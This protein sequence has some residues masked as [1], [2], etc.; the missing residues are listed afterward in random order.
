MLYLGIVF[1]APTRTL[2]LITVYSLT[3]V[4]CGKPQIQHGRVTG[5]TQ[6][7]NKDQYLTFECNDGYK[8]A[9]ERPSKCSKVGIRAEWSPTP[10]CEGKYPKRSHSVSWPH[11][12]LV[13]YTNR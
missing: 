2:V 5:D 12:S 13:Q 11:S 7:Y 8:P 10:M 6:L 3:V 4:T 1:C 9:E